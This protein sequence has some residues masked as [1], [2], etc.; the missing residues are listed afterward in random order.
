[1]NLIKRLIEKLSDWYKRSDHIAYA[2]GKGVL[3]GDNCRFVDN[4]S[5]GSE[6]YLISIGNHVLIS[7]NV[8]F[9]NHD[10][11]TWLFR[12]EGPYK[13]T[14]KFGP[15]TVGNNCFIGYGATILPSVNIGDNC[16]IAA[17]SIVTKDVP[18][19][20]VWGGV[21]AHF[22]TKTEDY[23]K[24]CYENRLPYVAEKLKNNKEAEM[25]RVCNIQSR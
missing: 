13:D 5:W 14:Y 2:K 9:I 8:T 3:V 12:E 25:K 18:S 21:P 20:E 6:P 16:I 10:G 24:K 23:A 4:P 19:G 1:M 17:G 11:A 15:I 7:G 22:I